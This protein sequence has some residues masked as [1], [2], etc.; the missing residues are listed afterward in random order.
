MSKEDGVIDKNAHISDE[1]IKRDIADTYD[2]INRWKREIEGYR[3]IGDRMSHFR[4][5]AR[6][7]YIKEAREFIDKLSGLLANRKP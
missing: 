7:S 5:D 4:A 1:E 2:D 6:V 3:L